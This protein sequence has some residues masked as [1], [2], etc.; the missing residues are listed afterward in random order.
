MKNKLNKD[1][2]YAALIRAIRSAA[3]AA[4]GVFTVGVTLYEVNWMYVMSVA[5]AAGVYSILTSL[6]VNLPE[7]SSDGTLEIDTTNPEKDTYRFNMDKE[8]EALK[9]KKYV[10]LKVNKDANLKSQK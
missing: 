8:L 5:G 1:W 6:A 7:V 10:K 4:L 3:Q 2:F 9:G